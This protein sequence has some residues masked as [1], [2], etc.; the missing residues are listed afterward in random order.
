M[1][2][3]NK[4]KLI[5]KETGLTFRQYIKTVDRINTSSGK[6]FVGDKW[7][8]VLLESG[9]PA[10]YVDIAHYPYMFFL[11]NKEWRIE[12]KPASDE[13]TGDVDPYLQTK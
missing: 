7:T 8:P 9:M 1:S 4:W 6:E 5:H 13:P 3:W 11:N 10:V 12:I 2:K